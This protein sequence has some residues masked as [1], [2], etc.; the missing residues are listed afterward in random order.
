M[1]S[2]WL[3]SILLAVSLLVIVLTPV[4]SM[5]VSAAMVLVPLLA[6]TMTAFGLIAIG[7]LRVKNPAIT[8]EDPHSVEIGWLVLLASL[9]GCLFLAS[10]RRLPAYLGW[11]WAYIVLAMASAPFA[12][13]VLSISLMKATVLL[14]GVTTVFIAVAALVEG[15]SSG[16][17]VARLLEISFIAVTLASLP[18]LAWPDVGFARNG[19]GFQSIVNQPQAFAVVYSPLVA[20]YV[21]FALIDRQRTDLLGVLLAVLGVAIVVSTDSR[22]GLAAVIIGLLGAILAGAIRSGKYAKRGLLFLAG[23]AVV[24]AIVVKVFGSAAMDWLIAFAV[25]SEEGELSVES[26][27]S[28]RAI[29]IQLG[30]TNFLQNP[31]LGIGF[32]MPSLPSALTVA[33]VG[34]MGIPLSVP[35]EK[36]NGFL[37]ILEETGIVGAAVMLIF[38]FKFGRAAAQTGYGSTVALW[39][40]ALAVNLGE[41][42]LLS[43]GGVGLVTWLYMVLATVGT[44]AEGRRGWLLAWRTT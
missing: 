12:S 35:I 43:L 7:W 25:K 28:S 9:V 33:A 39:A 30:W 11:F 18:L 23:V 44:V 32:G 31:I 42:V 37:Q 36:G 16:G 38:F 2:T 6:P 19:T 4:V 41:A 8:G 17:S 13:L 10:R 15:R 3:I 20:W 1:A 21:A 40:G 22:T 27:F 26:A 14:V 34:P 5:L 24:I 29:L